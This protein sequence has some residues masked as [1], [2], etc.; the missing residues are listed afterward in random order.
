MLCSY[1][2]EFDIDILDNNLYKYI[3]FVVFLIKILEEWKKVYD[4]KLLLNV[5]L[6]KVFIWY[7]LF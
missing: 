6:F 5:R 1:V 4:G 3:L 7:I 2:N